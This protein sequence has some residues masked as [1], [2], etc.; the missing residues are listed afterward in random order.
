MIKRN[1]KIFDTLNR[2]KKL[3]EA[4]EDEMQ[5]GDTPTEGG[6]QPQDATEAP[7]EGDAATDPSKQA[8]PNAGVFMSD[9]QKAEMAKMILD[10]LMMTPPEPGTIP[11]NLMNVTTD[12]A[13]EVIKYIQGLNALSAPL[14]LNND[15]DG[16]S[17]AGALKEI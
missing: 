9:N 10:A 12:N 3:Y 2:Y 11:P 17:M 1:F 13:D 15:S 8:D 16:N 14:A 6:E 4:A 5:E 7:A